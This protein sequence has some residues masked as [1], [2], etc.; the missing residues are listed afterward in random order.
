[1]RIAAISALAIPVIAL[2]GTTVPFT[3][4]FEDGASNWVTGGFGPPTEFTS[5]GVG[6]SAYISAQTGF[7]FS[8]PG[9]FN[10]VFRG[11][12]G[13]FPGTD[14]SDG[15]F[16]G[17]WITDGVTNLSFSIRHNITEPV[18]VFARI[19][20]NTGGGPFP[21]AVAVAFQPVVAG[22]WTTVSIDISAGNPAFVSFEGS[23]F[24]S[25]LS[26]V[27]FLQIGVAAPDAL[28]G[29]PGVFD[30]DLDNVSIVPTPAAAA[31]LLP[32][33]LAVRRRR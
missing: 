10:V 11:N 20:A 22:E 30:I 15:A 4:D 18:T 9:G 31:V 24:E 21:G 26:N 3:E 14:A 25:I 5:G 8:D 17:N 7:E 23:D 6:D 13:F 28:A 12:T 19:A 16:I 32:G 29:T 1:M 2:A 33:L 27:G